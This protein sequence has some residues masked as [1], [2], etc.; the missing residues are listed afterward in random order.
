MA[1]QNFLG[2]G[3]ETALYSLLVWFQIHGF[4]GLI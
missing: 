3:V 2:I 1:L 4:P